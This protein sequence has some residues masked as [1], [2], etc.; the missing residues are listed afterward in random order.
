[1]GPPPFYPVYF[2]SNPA[3]PDLRPPLPYDIPRPHNARF[4]IA[5]LCPVGIRHGVQRTV[6]TEYCITLQAQHGTVPR[7][8]AQDVHHCVAWRTTVAIRCSSVSVGL[9]HSPAWA[10]EVCMTV[11]RGETSQWNRS[12]CVSRPIGPASGSPRQMR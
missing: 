1:M 9:S 12:R 8:N 10:D 7:P 5:T 11:L 3:Q 6:G 2:P 4:C